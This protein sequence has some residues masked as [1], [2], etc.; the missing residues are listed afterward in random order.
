MYYS[1]L[2]RTVDNFG[3]YTLD[4]SFMD[5]LYAPPPQPYASFVRSTVLTPAL[6]SSDLSEPEAVEVI[7]DFMNVH[8]DYMH[9]RFRSMTEKLEKSLARMDDLDKFK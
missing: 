9:S 3:Y 4:L 7:F 8:L 1:N 2:E 6:S 5:L